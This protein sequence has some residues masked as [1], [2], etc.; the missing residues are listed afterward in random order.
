MSTPL[1][2]AIAAVS[3][4][5]EHMDAVNLC[6]LY[7]AALAE[8]R[9][10]GAVSD[11]FECFSTDI[12]KECDD[13]TAVRLHNVITDFIEKCPCHPNVGSAFR[14]LLTLGV[15]DDLKGYF[16]S[17]LKFYHGQGDAQTVF[18]LCTVLADMGVDVFRDETGAFI[19]SRSSCEAEQNL[20]VARR[21][22]ERC[23][24][25]PSAAPNG[26]PAASVDNPNAPG[27]PPSVS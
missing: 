22:L 26:G 6:F 24:A 2:D 25:E 19:P 12:P 4:E 17:K 3:A 14:T 7:F 20:G 18:Q 15:S 8:T 16:I 27:G 1:E 9:R 5:Y 13:A 10:R 11:L 21:F 23:I